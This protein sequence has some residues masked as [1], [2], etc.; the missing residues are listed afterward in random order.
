MRQVHAFRVARFGIVVER[1][2]LPL[3]QFLLAVGELA[4]AQLRTLQIG[5]NAD[6]PSD[7]RFDAADAAHQ[8]PHQI[9]IC[10]AHIDAKDVRAR[11]EQFANHG[12]VV[13]RWA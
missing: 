2:R 5:Q 13:R 11:I 7:G 10:V 4:D 1:E 8:G 3:D 12:F 6:R 9:V